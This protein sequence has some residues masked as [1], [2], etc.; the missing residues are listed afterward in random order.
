MINERAIDL[1][2]YIRNCKEVDELEVKLVE[3]ETSLS[4]I[5]T[6]ITALTIGDNP[7]RTDFLSTEYVELYSRILETK[8][9]KNDLEKQI[10]IFQLEELN[11]D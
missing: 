11:R 8:L 2:N 1:Y 7:E 10:I 5:D 3:M 9:Q 4:D 6:K